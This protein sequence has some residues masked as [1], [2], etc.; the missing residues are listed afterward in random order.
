EDPEPA[1]GSRPRHDPGDRRLGRAVGAG[2]RDET[3]P[4]RTEGSEARAGRAEGIIAGTAAREGIGP[5]H[6]CRRRPPLAPRRLLPDRPEQDREARLADA[7]HRPGGGRLLPDPAAPTR[8]APARLLGG[9]RLD[10]A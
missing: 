4:A 1:R 6:L 5:G 10:R 8:A 7:D 3:A 2:G 9:A